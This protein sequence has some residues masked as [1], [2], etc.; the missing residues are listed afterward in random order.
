MESRL[1]LPHSSH[2][3]QLPS[4]ITIATISVYPF[5]LATMESRLAFLILFAF[6]S[7]PFSNNIATIS[8]C[9]FT[10]CQN[11]EPYRHPSSVSHSHQLPSANNIATILF[12][13]IYTCPNESRI[14]AITILR[15]HISSIL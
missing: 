8:L 1:S 9:P 10:T 11:G 5:K 14:A 15:I 6:T 4:P 3:H 12:V 2:S 7:A 13:S